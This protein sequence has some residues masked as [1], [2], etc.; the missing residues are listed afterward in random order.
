MVIPVIHLFYDRGFVGRFLATGRPP[1]QG[2]V[3]KFERD[4]GSKVLIAV[5]MSI[6]DCNVV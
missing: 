1:V 2:V 4:T 5:A 6:L 3:P